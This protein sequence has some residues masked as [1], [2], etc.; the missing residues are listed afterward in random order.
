MI[1]CMII[2]II[3]HYNVSITTDIPAIPP[4][5]RTVSDVI[6]YGT[7]AITLRQGLD[8][9]SGNSTGCPNSH[10]CIHR[11]IHR[12]P[13]RVHIQPCI[14]SGGVLAAMA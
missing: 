2:N 13:H 11:L 14:D 9:V 1:A 4:I 8:W 12:I 10:H 5:L 3:Q 6:H 7:S